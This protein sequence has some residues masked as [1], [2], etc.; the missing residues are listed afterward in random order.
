[1]DYYT[2]IEKLYKLNL[3]L[4]YNNIISTKD[5]STI[6]P[7]YKD[8]NIWWTADATISRIMGTDGKLSVVNRYSHEFLCIE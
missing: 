3:E 8:N 7:L 1:M 5:I 2:V 4:L 6:H